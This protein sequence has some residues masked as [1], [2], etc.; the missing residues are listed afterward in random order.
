MN[1]FIKKTHL[2]FPLSSLKRGPRRLVVLPCSIR[3]NGPVR[4]PEVSDVPLNTLLA[5]KG[6]TAKIQPVEVLVRVFCLRAA[7]LLFERMD[8]PVWICLLI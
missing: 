4:R 7:C 6:H 1:R 3:E 2:P 8:Q 5:T